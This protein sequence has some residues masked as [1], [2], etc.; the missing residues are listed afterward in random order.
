MRLIP[1][2]LIFLLTAGLGQADQID[3]AGRL[4]S[5]GGSS[6]CSASLIR[7]DVIV[8]AA[9]CAR[10]N[11]DDGIVF[12]PGDGQTGQTYAVKRFVRHPLYDT[13]SSRTEWRY[14]FDIAVGELAEAVPESRAGLL[15]LG[16]DAQLGET[17]FIVSWRWFEGNR[18][19]QRACPVIPGLRGLVTLG[20]PVEN[21]ESGA[22]V[23][24]KTD[25]GLELVA[26]IS[27]RGQQLDQPIA[28]AS[29]VRLRI[30]PL[31]DRLKN[32]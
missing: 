22:P 23:I 18:P 30:P 20:C 27:S 3:A 11:P 9:H 25:G 7:R 31:L 16:D 6:S 24:R 12:R 2:I 17:L 29:D 19:R 1:G 4:E 8:T 28:Q 32:P 26:I 13:E 14:R 5:K 21:G 10:G 15:P